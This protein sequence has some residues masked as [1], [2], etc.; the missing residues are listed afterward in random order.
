MPEPVKPPPPP[1]SIKS[2][3]ELY[4]T[5]LRLEQF[6]NPAFEPYPYYEEA[7]KRDPGD[8]R[9]N[10]ALGILYL[11]RGMFNEAEKKLRQ[12]IRRISKD[13]TSPKNG[14][15]FY[16]LGVALHALGRMDEACDAFTKAAW[17]QAWGAASYY[18]LAE[19]ASQRRNYSKALEFLNRSLSLNALNTKALNFKAGLLRKLGRLQEAEKIARKVLHFDP[20]DFWAGNELHKIMAAKGLEKEELEAKNSLEA[21]M[22][23][24]VQS[25]LELAVDYGN[26]GFVN[27]AVEAISHLVEAEGGGFSTYPMLHYYLGYYL[28]KKGDKK[29]AREYYQCAS[30]MPADYCFPFR[31]ES[32]EVLRRA[33]KINPGDARAPYYLGNLLYD[34]QPEA[35]MKEWEKSR[36]L[37]EAFPIIHRNLGLAYARVENNIPEAIACME[38]AL[39]CN[40]KDARY[41]YELDLLYETGSVSPEKRLSLFEK[42]HETALQRDDAL[43]REIMLLVQLGKHDR[44]IDLLA[45]HH[46]HVWEG[47]GRIHSVYV[48]AHLLKGHEHFTAGRFNEALESFS[49]ALEY[50]KNLEVGRPYSGGRAAQVY[51]FI[52]TVYEAMDDKE[53]AKEYYEDL[54]AM[55]YEVSEMSYY[56]GLAFRKLG[57]EEKASQIFEKLID[58][59]K[60]RLQ[61]ASSMDF[62]AKFGERQS[63]MYR[64]ANASYLLGL[65]YLGRGDKEQARTQFKNS[66]EMNLNH[67]WAKQQLDWLEWRR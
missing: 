51:Y 22:R 45:A 42:N 32:I 17:S 20:L 54:V 27:E 57:R 61:A 67:I 14:E 55:E 34:L 36:R 13:Y 41:L 3:E 56:Q 7:L 58:F 33:Q 62:F 26:C 29:K 25:Y 23:N 24:A 35:A 8:S 6:H 1:E 4:L 38:K 31:L 37:D 39:S 12:A 46:F 64:Q 19:L 53:K 9:V 63:A 15:A 66:L 16:Y 52:G 44:A 5:G 2:I 18:S 50:P 10:T 49:A 65:G 60:Q 30:Q 28:E 59:G 21:K 47:G 43:S 11:K 48:D 40:S